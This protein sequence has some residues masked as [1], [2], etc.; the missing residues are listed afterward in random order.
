M[1]TAAAITALDA[2]LALIEHEAV[3][4]RARLAALRAAGAITS[5]PQALAD[6]QETWLP[7]KAAAMDCGFSTERIRLWAVQHPEL[8][9]RH[10]GQWR[11]SATKLAE[12]IRNR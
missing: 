1:T 7:L 11:I 5:V 10:G 3:A 12:F 8:S 2:E 9:K 4:L 6:T